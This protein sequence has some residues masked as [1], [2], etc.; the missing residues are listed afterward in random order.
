MA[1]VSQFFDKE[2][3]QQEFNELADAPVA[4]IQG[5]SEGDAQKLQQ[6]SISRRCVIWLRTS[7][8]A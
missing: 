5:L 8:C 4:A 7:S 6:A 2:Y 3:E 1:D